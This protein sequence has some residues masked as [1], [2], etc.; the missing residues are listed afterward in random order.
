MIKN[1]RFPF[2]LR[3]SFYIHCLLA[4]LTLVGGK[5]ILN[6]QRILQDQNIELVKASVRVDMVAMPEHTLQEIKAMTE[7]KPVTPEP[8]AE[9]VVEAPAEVK[10]EVSA[11][12]KNEEKVD[13]ANEKIEVEKR[14]SFLD[15]LKNLS[16]QKIAKTKS[17]STNQNKQELKQLV[18]AGNKLSKGTEAYGDSQSGDQTAFQIYI[19]QL[20]QKVKPNWH[21]PSFLLDK[22]LNCRVR[23]WISMNGHLSRAEIYQS[24]GDNEYDQKALEAV[25]S[26]S[27]F[28]ELT[29]E[30]GKRAL[31]GEILLGFPL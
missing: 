15:K 11:E 26:S 3:R 24:S 27:P 21:L 20:P 19:S 13:I 1:A 12:K 14:Q 18:L 8:V 23:I 22:K 10:T 28:P 17:T 7:D 2:Y 4:I 31:N 6:Q 5:I 25:R 9:K 29:S 30:F 16:K